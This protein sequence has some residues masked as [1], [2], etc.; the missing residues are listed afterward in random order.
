MCFGSLAQGSASSAAT[1]ECFLRNTQA[2]TLRICDANLRQRFYDAD[3]LRRSFQ[4]GDIV[5]ANDRELL[6]ISSL[7]K[8]DIGNEERM[9]QE[10]LDQFHL[11]MV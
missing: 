5:K 10:L 9:A 3:T 6:E 7:L 11:M 1:I 8:I 4:H 2:K